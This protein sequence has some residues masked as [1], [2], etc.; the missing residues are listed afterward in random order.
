MPIKS[1]YER[2]APT[3]TKAFLDSKFAP[4]GNDNEKQICHK[5]IAFCVDINLDPIPNPHELKHVALCKV[6]KAF[7][8]L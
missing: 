2:Y 1:T 8:L 5:A 4:D 3:F 7:K 6:E